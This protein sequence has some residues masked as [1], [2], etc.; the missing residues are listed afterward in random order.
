ML[1][2]V[3]P[4]SVKGDY[5]FPTAKLY[6]YF[7]YNNKRKPKKKRSNLATLCIKM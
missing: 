4:S 5:Y 1:Y 3:F 2:E 7:Y 6:K